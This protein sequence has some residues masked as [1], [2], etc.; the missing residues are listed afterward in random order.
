[1]SNA[2]DKANIPVLNFQSKGIDD[3]ATST[4]ITINSSQNV[5]IGT[6]SP[7]N[8]SNYTGL[9]LSGSTGSQVVLQD[10]GTTEA[11]IWNNNA[12]NI[13]A[14]STNPIKFLTN[15]SERM[16]IANNGNI[17]IGTTNTSPRLYVVSNSNENGMILDCVGTPSNYHFD[18][19]NDNSSIFRIDS[20]GNVG[21]GTSSPGSMRLLVEGGNVYIKDHLIIGTGDSSTISS[22]SSGNP[23]LFGINLVEKMRINTNG[24]VGI[25]TTS[26]TQKLDVNGTV[27]ATAFQGDGSALTGVGGANTPAFE[28]YLSTNQSF[29]NTTYQKV[30]FDTE[31]YDTDSDYD[32]STNYR[33][34]PT[35]AGKYLVYSTIVMYSTGG[36][37]ISDGQL[38]IYK[39]GSL[40]K[41]TDFEIDPEARINF[42]TSTVID[43]NGSSDYVEIYGYLNVSSGTPTFRG[44][45]TKQCHFG[46]FKI[47]T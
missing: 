19:R 9:T 16:R 45:G 27:K 12:F 46:A 35:T 5:G 30:E 41:E 14:K 33:F 11:L 6:N 39:N 32:N 29:S 28:A 31:I 38:A 26:P 21:I 44:S 1:M 10:D 13:E 2:R 7:V 42:S 25:G 47:I 23:L 17:G 3:N 22:D 24:N 4:A 36:A 37:T 40:Y 15:N 8:D 20:S 34:T 43:F 18:V